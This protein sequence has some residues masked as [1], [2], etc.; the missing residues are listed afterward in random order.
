VLSEKSITRPFGHDASS[1]KTGF[2]VASSVYQAI[3]T[4]VTDNETLQVPIREV[5]F[6]SN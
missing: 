5:A 2:P 6:T 3:I 1:V 4:Q